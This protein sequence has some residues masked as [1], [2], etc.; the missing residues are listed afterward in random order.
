MAKYTSEEALNHILNMLD[1]MI[2]RDEQEKEEQQEVQLGQADKNIVQLLQG[3]VNTTVKNP[4]SSAGMQLKALSQGMQN[5]KNIDANDIKNVT[6]TLTEIGRSMNSLSIKKSSLDSL[7]T[8]IS[9]LTTAGLIS[10]ANVDG[11]IYMTSTI[12]EGMINNINNLLNGLSINDGVELQIQKLDNIIKALNNIQPGNILQL[13]LIA[14]NISPDTVDKI[15]DQFN[16]LNINDLAIEHIMNLNRALNILSNIAPG[17]IAAFD[18][19]VDNITLRNIQSLN[20]ALQA[21]DIDDSSISNSIKLFTALTNLSALQVVPNASLKVFLDNLNINELNDFIRSINGLNIEQSAFKNINDLSI[22]LQSMH[23]IDPD[24]IHLFNQLIDNISLIKLDGVNEFISKLNFSDTKFNIA[25]LINII[26]ELN[27]IPDVQNLDN[28][29]K[30][31][32]INIL[33][34]TK[35]LDFINSINVKNPKDAIV[36]TKALNELI[37][38]FNNIALIDVKNLNDNLAKLD[39]NAGKR[40]GDFLNSIIKNIPSDK[41]TVKMMMHMSQFMKGLSSIIDTGLLNMKISLN[42]LKGKILGRQIGDFLKAVIS[43]VDKKK[44]DIQIKGIGELLGALAKFGDKDS[45]ISIFRIRRFINGKNGEMIGAFFNNL[46]KNIPVGKDT[47]KAIHEIAELFKALSGITVMQA[48]AIRRFAG[49]LGPKE[50]KAINGF[51]KELITDID[52]IK[53]KEANVMLKQ[54]PIAMMYIAGSIAVLAGTIALFGIVNTVAALG[55]ISVATTGMYMVIKKLSGIKYKDAKYAESIIQQIGKVTLILTGT[56]ALNALIV[57]A[58]PEKTIMASLGI[59]GVFLTGITL[60]TLLLSNKTFNANISKAGNVIND[61]SKTILLLSGSMLLLAGVAVLINKVEWDAVKFTIGMFGAVVLSMVL[62]SKLVDNNKADMLAM[63]K[64]LF[65]TLAA[66]T[67]SLYLMANFIRKYKPGEIV[68]SVLLF[69]G[70]ITATILI[71]KKLANSNKDIKSASI[72]LLAI[73]GFYLLTSVVISKLVIPIGEEIL[74]ATLGMTAL[75]LFTGFSVYIANRIGSQKTLKQMQTGIISL[76][77]LTLIM[78]GTSLIIK[79][80][81]IPIG[82]KWGRATVGAVLMLSVIGI[83]ALMTDMLVKKMSGNIVKSVAVVGILSFLLLGVSLIIKELLI[84]IGEQWKEAVKGGAAVIGIMGVFSLLVGAFANFVKPELQAKMA[85]AGILLGGL[86]IVLSLCIAPAYLFVKLAKQVSQIS[87]KDILA[88]GA[89]VT[90]ILAVGGGIVA[91]IAAS[92]FVGMGLILAAEGVLAGL[93]LVLTLCMKPAFLFVELSRQV[94]DLKEG[95]IRQTTASMIAMFTGISAAIT[96]L[97]VQS[98]VLA[99]AAPLI[100]ITTLAISGIMS[101]V[102]KAVDLYSYIDEHLTVK[103]IQNVNKI[104][105]EKD[106]LIDS[107]TKIVSGLD[108]ISKWAVIKI[109]VVTPAL[110][111]IFGTISEFIDVITKVSTMSYISGYDSRGKP[112]Y[113]KLPASVFS[114]AAVAVTQSFSTFIKTLADNFNNIKKLADNTIAKMGYCMI[115]IMHTISKFV[116][117]VIKVATMNIVMGYDNNGKPIYEHVQPD[118]FNNAAIVVSNN[119]NKFIVK[120][121]ESIDKLSGGQQKAIKQISKVMKPIMKAVSTFVDT[122]VKLITSTYVSGYDDNGKPI[123]ETI[124]ISEFDRA[125]EIVSTNFGRFINSMNESFKNIEPSTAKTIKQLGKSLGPIMKGISDYINAIINVS[126]LMIPDMWDEDG[127]PI[128]FIKVNSEEFEIA[129]NNVTASF[130]TFVDALTDQFA[131]S[132]WGNK[133]KR[134]L[135]AIGENIKPVMEGLMSYTDSIL[136]LATGTYIDH[137]V[138]DANGNYI[139]LYKKIDPEKDFIKA[140]VY[141]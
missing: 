64:S 75:L 125:A 80:I 32:E 71:F 3:I 24:N 36:V 22:L 89:I 59:I 115:P 5:L 28:K 99:L 141:I 97:S 72:A 137:Y 110:N 67:G 60:V 65:I 111:S 47:D 126:T 51:I 113:T 4:D 11:L 48:F 124:D 84:P 94:A 82:E 103:S 50:G 96:I 102:K 136:K 112:I 49:M 86:A 122:I 138:K 81:L 39:P 133:T 9:F 1:Y 127:K 116:D 117:T 73:S 114:T 74:A 10:K 55:I 76:A 135:N 139:P 34:S 40:L 56:L 54:L 18:V 43:A 35:L 20:T 2:V 134:A 8:L 63:S 25:P 129:A 109:S 26:S 46:V 31:I 52:H 33:N 123:Y 38:C 58:F 130:A 91:L 16:R 93:A 6:A 42:P 61:I 14:D 79:E 104:I 100:G 140:A 77:A 66:F 15:N 98:A 78:F 29:I 57:S 85:S 23:N 27:K 62:I 7:T 44:I 70:F 69:T 41:D 12:N 132:W 83:G 108:K 107:I 106:G 17:N 121:G 87:A 90:S 131:G 95:T 128:H 45:H 68:G 101:T 88:T 30:F 119:F 53:L 118:V 37:S 13:K 19:F 120:L 21:I 92:N 105:T